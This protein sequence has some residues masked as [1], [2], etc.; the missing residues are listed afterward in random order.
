MAW[1]T[2]LEEFRDAGKRPAEKFCIS[3]S[4]VRIKLDPPVEGEKTTVNRGQEKAPKQHVRSGFP[5]DRGHSQNGVLGTV[6]TMATPSV[7]VLKNP[8]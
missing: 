2:A 5:A 6:V 3:V 4:T 7:G 8:R 1:G